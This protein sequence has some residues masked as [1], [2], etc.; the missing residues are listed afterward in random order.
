MWTVSGR[1]PVCES[2]GK[3]RA[4]QTLREVRRC[5]AVAP[6]FGLRTLQ[7]RF[8]TGSARRWR[9]IFGGSPKIS[10]HKLTP[11]SDKE[12][13][14]KVWASRP[15]RHAGRMRYHSYFGVRVE[16]ICANTRLHIA[17]PPES[18]CAV[19]FFRS[20][21]SFV[22]V[23]LPLRYLRVDPAM[24]VSPHSIGCDFAALCPCAKN[25]KAARIARSG[26]DFVG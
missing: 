22:R 4:V 20:A 16:S 2:G 9:A 1:V 26:I 6:A 18:S 17:I 5:P 23:F 14:T 3:P 24:W 15:N 21:D 25:K 13:E 8:Y 7:R 11:K 10:S 19:R 12:C